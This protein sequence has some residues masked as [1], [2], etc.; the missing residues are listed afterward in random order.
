MPAQ[1][2]RN[3]DEAAGDDRRNRAQQ[4]RR[5]ARLEGAELVRRADEYVLD[6]VHPAAQLARGCQRGDRRADV[7]RDHVDEAA[8]RQ[9]EQRQPEPARQPEHDH[10]DAEHADDEEQR[11]PGATAEGAARKA[12]ARDERADRGRA[13][14]DA[15]PERPG[16]E[17]RPGKQRQER[18]GAAEQD[19][20]QVE[21]DCAE[22]DRG[23]SDQPDAAE[24][25][26]E[27]GRG[28]LPLCTRPGVGD[29]Q[30]ADSRRDEQRD[31]DHVQRLRVDRKQ[32]AADGGAGDGREL[33]RDR[34]EGEGTG[35]QLCG[36]DLGC[37]R[38]PGRRSERLCDAGHRSQDDER[39]QLVRSLDRHH[40]EEPGD[41]GLGRDRG[42]KQ[43]NPGQPVGDLACGQ[44][45]QGQGHELRQTDQAEVERAPVNRVDL[46][47]DRDRH[48]LRREPRGEKAAP[49]PAEVTVVEGR[50][51]LPARGAEHRHGAELCPWRRVE[52]V[53]LGFPQVSPSR[54]RAGRDSLEA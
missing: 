7:H 45:E 34:A 22:E 14:Q 51:Q 36:D 25:A 31:R 33:A 16:V 47:A 50:R 19:G 18:D 10:A 28:F 3:R 40:E 5:C 41:D 32:E 4:G 53:F 20:K 44:R 43:P 37:Q 54:L 35:E 13:A 17:D 1:R 6:R 49:Q 15:E 42:G 8:D 12:D 48:H 9:R 27:T 38:A 29:Q 24:Q 21:R 11:P 2:E 39:P 26:L 46:P 52:R 30:H 23:R